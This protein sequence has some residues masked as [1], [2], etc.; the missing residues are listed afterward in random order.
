MTVIGRHAAMRGTW[1]AVAIG[2]GLAMSA[3]GTSRSAS[4]PEVP[5][6]SGPRYEITARV[7]DFG[8]GTHL[9]ILPV[10]G[11]GGDPPSAACGGPSVAG[12]DWETTD[13]EESD[14]AR[15]GT[16]HLVGTW[17]GTTLTLTEPPSAPVPAMGD[18]DS[19]TINFDPPC[20]EPPGGWPSG[21]V[22]LEEWMDF[23]ARIQEPADYAGSWVKQQSDVADPTKDIMTI[24]YT[25]D[26][27]AHRAEIEAYWPN[28]ICV[29]QHR[30][31]L[32][33]L[34]R[35]AE[36]VM[37]SDG[38]ALSFLGGGVD[39]FG[40]VVRISVIAATPEDQAMLDERYGPGVV[41]LQGMMKPVP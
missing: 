12:L 38:P 36:E 18:D 41:E 20:P 24:A 1:V 26:P 40:G 19:R 2:A 23:R 10:A 6:A 37:R 3:C 13:H 4:E 14:G 25:G 33:E 32:T 5:A 30:T 27:D 34:Q 21:E 29:I 15:T 7:G 16:Y 9:C 28:P 11:V 35:I 22:T 39:Q 17:D 31:T 8:S